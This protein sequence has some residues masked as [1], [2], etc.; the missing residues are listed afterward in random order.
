MGKFDEGDGLMADFLKYY[1][2]LPERQ[3]ELKIL[4]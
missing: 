1:L 3:N 2:Y 4:R